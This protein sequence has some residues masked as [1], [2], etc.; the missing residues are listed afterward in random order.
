MWGVPVFYTPFFQHADIGV[1]RQTG[2]LNPTFSVSSGSSG[3][4]VRQ[5]YF[6]VLDDDKDVTLSTIARVSGDPDPPGGVLTGEYRQR[7]PD[8]A[9]ILGASGTYEAE[10]DGDSD[11]EFRGHVN[12]AGLFDLNRD[13][14]WGFNFK[15]TTD[16][17]YLRQYHLGSQRWLQDT[18]WGEGFLGRSYF[19]ARGF[20]WQTTDS[21][22][23]DD[24]API[25]TPPAQLQ[26]HQ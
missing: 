21:D 8:G 25:I 18:L 9:L 13:W 11:R 7:V 14:R 2:L 15:N 24:T 6:I 19:E 4:Q 26:L 20:G 12:G 23:R 16:K 22:L 17:D 5:P 10:P 1:Q 3:V